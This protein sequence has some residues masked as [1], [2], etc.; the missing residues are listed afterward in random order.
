M[1]AVERACVFG[2]ASPLI[3]V[4]T[5][6]E[7]ATSGRPAALLLNAGLMHRIGAQ[8]MSVEIAR[9]LAPLGISSLRF[10]VSGIGDSPPRPDHLPFA[11]SSVLETI[12]AMDWMDDAGNDAGYLLMGLCSGADQAFQVAL[13]DERVRGV[14]LIDPYPYETRGFRLR[15]WTNPLRRLATWQRAVRGGYHITYRVLKR[16]AGEYEEVEDAGLAV[17]QIPPRAEAE[18]GY[19][20]LLD[21]GVRVNVV[22]TGGQLGTYNYEKQFWDMHPSLRGRDGI[23]YIYLADADH[24]TSLALMRRALISHIARWAEAF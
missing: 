20:K 24:T 19:H 7:P 13:A 5:D 21:R 16:L 2:S 14:V 17:R 15:R 4:T 10:D 8:R 18:S 6:G 1:S 22:F 11:Q 23:E 12:E 3:G 9:A